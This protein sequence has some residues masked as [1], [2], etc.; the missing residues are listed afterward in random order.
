MILFAIGVKVYGS[1][2]LLQRLIEVPAAAL[3]IASGRND[4]L[5]A[6]R[7]PVSLPFGEI[8]GKKQH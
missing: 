8:A 2:P 3:L 1:H 6:T 7:E 5:Y 4:V